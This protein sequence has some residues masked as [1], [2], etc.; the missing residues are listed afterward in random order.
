MDSK[1]YY[2]IIL[3]FL[4]PLANLFGQETSL[5]HQDYECGTT[6]AEDANLSLQRQLDER[7]Q[8]ERDYY[9]DIVQGIRND[10]SR[11]I[12]NV[13]M[14][15]VQLHILR[16]SAGTG[17][18]DATE[19]ENALVLANEFFIKGGIYLYQCSAVNY[20]DDD[21]YYDYNKT[22]KS[23]LHSAYGVANV[24][25]IYSAN[26]VTSG[27]SSICGHAEFPGGLDFAMLD[28]DC[29]LNGSTF[30]HE[31]GHYFNVYHTHQ[32]GNELV[33][34]S[35]CGTA[36]DLLC[37]TPADPTLSSLVNDGGCAYT[38]SATD[39]NS[40]AYSP[41]TINIM[42][43]SAK[44]C[45][46]QFTDEQYARMLASID[47]DRTNLTCSQSLEA[48]FYS[49]PYAGSC[50]N[51]NVE[52]CN[53]STGSIT[54]YAWD[55]GDGGTSVD[56]SPTHTYTTA[57]SYDVQLTVGDGS[58]TDVETKN[59]EVAVG[60]VDMPYS[61][62][63][64]SGAS[65]LGRFK[66]TATYKN[67]VEVSASANNASTNGLAF[68]GYGSSPTTSSPYFQTPSSVTAFDD[69]WNSF[70][71]SATYLC[72]DGRNYSTITLGFDI[73]QMYRHSPSYSNFRITVN[74]T[75]VAIYQADGT[76]SWS[77]KSINLSAYD[78]TIFTIGFEG[79]HKYG[80][81]DNA[82]FIDNISLSGVLP[83]ELI[84]FEAKANS[85]QQVDLNW[86]TA[87]QE[88]F[89]HFEVEHSIDGEAFSKFSTVETENST[90]Q[91]SIQ[92]QTIHENPNNGIN[93]YRLKMVDLDETFEYSS[94][95]EVNIQRTTIAAPKFFPNPVQIGKSLILKV[96]NL[97]NARLTIY[98]SNGKLIKDL[99]LQNGFNQL[100]TNHLSS[101]IYFYT[102]HTENKVFNGKL[103]LV[104]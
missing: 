74:G 95:R 61:E 15:P 37:D 55:F 35:N 47:A 23:A 4:F 10:F 65:D 69:M 73:K 6:L 48:V 56:A 98:Q 44:G 84:S 58:G 83:V 14:V 30:A 59:Y 24:L 45:R 97:P 42:S 91:T 54:T 93:Y 3:I 57:G 17:G 2:S 41:S 16:T 75:Q 53:V 88:N 94:I 77:T 25:N 63:F 52:F 78:R 76:E 99:N 100:N 104:D 9:L 70:F 32:S 101:G 22:Q 60:A 85:N 92:Y 46:V 21:T 68:Y 20:I 13:R 11:N 8:G 36:G 50:D 67:Y 40:A 102:I 19:Y 28:N 79:S 12:S 43:Y 7:W 80:I 26:S 89:S 29:A 5:F 1:H 62:D 33:D 90:S 51:M 81:V 72:V 96:D 27:S 39:A 71:K 31:V 86:E 49:I 66:D 34:G 38:G 87:S 64:E 18:I 82:T 103:V